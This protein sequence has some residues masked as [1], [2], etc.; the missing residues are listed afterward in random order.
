M[1]KV[2][3][4]GSQENN[5]ERVEKDDYSEEWYA[6]TFAKYAYLSSI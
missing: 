2:C 5:M 3:S 1:Q 6:A 4:D